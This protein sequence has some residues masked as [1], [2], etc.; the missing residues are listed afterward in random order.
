[1]K[2][3]ICIPTY[4]RVDRLKKC[5]ES[6]DAELLRVDCEIEVAISDNDS[7]DGTAL[8]LKSWAFRNPEIVLKVYFQDENLGALANIKFLT[9]IAKGEYLLWITDDDYVSTGAISECSRILQ[10]HSPDFLNFNLVVFSEKSRTT[11]LHGTGF[12]LQTDKTNLHDF[13][14]IFSYSHV[15][16]GTC[17]RKAITL[18]VPEM[19]SKN[20][21]PM[22]LWCSL[23]ASNAMYSPYPFG[24]H[25]YENE[26]Y[27]TGDV[28][29]ASQMV[30][31]PQSEN[32]SFMSLN[33][34][35]EIAELSDLHLDI[36]EH[37]Y[38]R[39]KFLK[40]LDLE[41][42]L[43]VSKVKRI[44]IILKI[45]S[46][47]LYFAAPSVFRRKFKGNKAHHVISV[48]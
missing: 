6:L 43:K 48:S 39:K 26:I 38:S 25:T 23:S 16:T 1:M 20:I 15:L 33:L 46:R 37:F 13:I 30:K 9:T 2:L 17:V 11:F 7:R 21:Y 41:F 44:G 31:G 24:V 3:S 28:E 34:I 45:Q 40:K 47:K 42:D 5:L 35:P 14:K 32:D 8:F 10:L 4:N 19:Y 18:Q 36:Y 27:W 29:L 12:S 22:S